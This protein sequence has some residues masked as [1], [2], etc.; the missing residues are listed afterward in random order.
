MKYWHQLLSLNPTRFLRGYIGVLAVVFLIVEYSRISD[1]GIYLAASA[2]LLKGIDPYSVLYG[3]DMLFCYMGNPS[4]AFLMIPFSILPKLLAT[5]IWK[6]I[7]LVLLYRIWVL[8]EKYFQGLSLT[9]EIRNRLLIGSFLISFFL[10]FAN[11]HNNQFTILLLFCGLES[12]YQ[13]R[14]KSNAFIGAG[15]LS[16]GIMVKLLPLIL[17]PYL[18]YRGYWKASLYVLF[19][20]L[21]LIFLPALFL[22]W[23]TNMAFYNKWLYTIA[24]V[25]DTNIFDV[26]T[27]TIHGIGA[28]ISTLTFEGI[29]N[30]YSLCYP[31]HI[32]DL[33][34]Y[35]VKYLIISV[36]V[37]LVLITLYFLKIN[38]VFKKQNNKIA[39]L[40]ELSYLFLA[41]PLIFPQQRTYAFVFIIPAVVF[42]L[43]QIQ[44]KK[45]LGLNALIF[46]VGIIL[47]LELILGTFR[48][49]YWHYKI[50]TYAVLII[51][52]LLFWLKPNKA[53][54]K[55]ESWS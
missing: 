37:I 19:T 34:Y 54:D 50:I 9:F 30:N 51:L 17:L 40:W 26:S 11:F 36:K 20:L 8:I 55:S 46:M 42:V 18:I 41:A 31:R 38:T 15:I 47:N 35:T 32:V 12:I 7:N 49:Y 5:F 16:L 13:I 23:E 1:F 10:V 39:E 24:P 3:D 33:P 28:L 14:G 2:N 25:G 45:N 52:V 43:F 4:L 48:Q 53:N 29:G 44:K 21:I 22:G 27:R 6:A